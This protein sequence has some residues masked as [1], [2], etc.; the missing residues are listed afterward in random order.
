MATRT[1]S[2]VGLRAVF[3]IAV[4]L[5][6]GAMTSVGQ[7]YL[8]GALNAFV[9]SA[10]AWL[11]APLFVGAVMGTRRGAAGAGLAVAL[12]Q[13]LGYYITA[14]ARG[15]ST[16]GA[17][18]AFWAACAVV[19]GPLFGAGGH[20]WRHG[21]PRFAGLGS[22]LLPAAFLA[23]GLW[24]YLHELRYYATAA[25]WIAIGVALAILLPTGGIQRRWLP[26]T[27]ILGIAGE[28]AISQIYRQALS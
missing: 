10:S 3:V 22:T 12:M 26:L 21:S 17:I 9:N 14:H 2:P 5:A 28:I 24:V 18:V 27:L 11:V 4:G 16:G 6:V 15:Y 13:L 25:L 20:L 1:T 19:G 8:G 7:T 23:E